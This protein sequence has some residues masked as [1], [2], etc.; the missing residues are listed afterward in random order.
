MQYLFRTEA[1]IHSTGFSWRSE[2]T[3]TVTVSILPT[4]FVFLRDIFC[5][6]ASFWVQVQQIP[7]PMLFMRT[8]LQAIGAFP[9]LVTNS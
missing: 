1:D 4:Q 9:A 2:P 7:L 8:V 5:S 6:L 3:G